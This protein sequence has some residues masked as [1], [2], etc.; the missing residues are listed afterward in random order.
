MNPWLNENLPKYKKI[1]RIFHCSFSL[2]GEIVF[3]NYIIKD[4]EKYKK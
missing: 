1:W 3:L 2:I 4:M